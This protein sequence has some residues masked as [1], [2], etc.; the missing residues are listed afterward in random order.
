MSRVNLGPWPKGT[1]EPWA[2]LARRAAR[3]AVNPGVGPDFRALVERAA[4]MLRSGALEELRERSA[5]PRFQ[6]AAATAWLESTDLARATLRPRALDALK[7]ARPSRPTV[8]ILVS[9]LLA[10]FD[11]LDEWERGTFDAL[12]STLR[13]SI[14]A[15][16]R[17]RFTDVVDTV[18]DYR[19]AFFSLQG[20]ETLAARLLDAQEDIYGWFA[21]TGL[22][23]QLESRFGRRARDAYYLTAI[24]HAEP[25]KA[26]Q[27]LLDGVLDEVLLRQRTESTEED[28]LYFGHLVLT[29]LTA[30]E[31]RMPSRAWMHLILKIGGDPRTTGTAEWR[32]WWSRVPTANVERATRWMSGLDLKAFLEGIAAY[33][34]QTRNHDMQRMFK[35]RKRLL[36]GLFDLDLVREVRLFLG[37]EIR[38]WIT[39]SSMTALPNSV[40]LTG[41]NRRHTAVIYVDC[42]DFHL[43]EGTHSFPIHVYV[44]AAPAVVK[45]PSRRMIS[46]EDFKTELEW[47]LVGE[48]V[49]DALKSTHH[50]NWVFR[51]LEILRRNG[52]RLDEKVLMTEADF[53]DLLRRRHLTRR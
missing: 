16:P 2:D 20:P 6:R 25:T 19:E 45:N 44:G 47:A 39:R 12:A 33:A 32:T 7:A 53:A 40:T 5:D 35:T 46:D 11:Q 41:S 17:A 8:T 50:G 30:H 27:K 43:V 10:H 14:G 48:G 29:E 18:R 3:L 26:D 28:R 13:E 38:G 49:R 42:G 9:L 36:E 24:R 4:Q 1:F 34:E 15:L 51:A 22:S 37:P 52:I 31:T 21:S 23:A